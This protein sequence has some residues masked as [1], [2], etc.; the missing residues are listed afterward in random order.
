MRL[1]SVKRCPAQYKEEEEEE[2]YMIIVVHGGGG[3]EVVGVDRGGD[4][5]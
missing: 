5:G 4:G 2:I 3:P 1:C